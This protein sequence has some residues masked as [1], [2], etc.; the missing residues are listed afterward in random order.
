LE[1]QNIAEICESKEQLLFYVSKGFAAILPKRVVPSEELA[2][3]RQQL[4]HWVG[5]RAHF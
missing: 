2:V 5:E 1:W 4:R 3:L